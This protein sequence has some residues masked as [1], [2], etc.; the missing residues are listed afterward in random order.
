VL[1]GH[2]TWV[3]SVAW[4]GD[5]RRIASGS[6]D[7]TVRIWD[8][9]SGEM[10]RV[11]E[12]HR[13]WVRSVAW[14]GDGRRIAS[15]SADNTVRIWDSESGKVL[16][17]HKSGNQSYDF[18]DVAFV[19]IVEMAASLG[20]TVLGDPAIILGRLEP[21]AAGLYAAVISKRLRPVG[22]VSA[23]V[24]PSLAEETVQVVSAK[25]VLMGESGAGKSGLALRLAED[26]F[27]EQSSTHGMRRWRIA[28]ETLG[29]PEVSARG[30]KREVV[31]WD[32][33]GQDEYRL[34]HQL[35][36]HDTMI[37]LTVLD[38]TRDSAFEDADEWNLRLA[39]QSGRREPARLLVGSKADQIKNRIMIDKSRIESLIARWKMGPFRLTSA[40]DGSG[41]EELRESVGALINWDGL[42]RTSR[43]RL[44]QLIR[45]IIDERG[46]AGE[47]V[48]MYSDLERRI[49]EASPNE[50]DG[51]SVESVVQELARQGVITD[52][53]LSTG[54][55]ALVLGIDYVD[56]YAGSLILIARENSRVR[57]VPA[58]EMSEAIFR[59]SFP[60]IKEEVRLDPIQERHVMECVIGLMIEKGICLRHERLLVF[61]TLF[62]ETASD[63]G[64]SSSALAVPL[65]YD[66]SGAISN[67]YASLIARL[68]VGEMFGRVRLWKDRAEFD[69]PG[70]GVCGLRRIDRSGGWSHMD[71]LFGEETNQATR[72]LFT[73]FVEEH[74]THEGVAIREV[75]EMTCP[76]CSYRFDEI[77]VR[78][79]IAKGLSEI[80]CPWPECDTVSRISQG[81][82][83]MRKSNPSVAE[84]LIAL[85]KTS[86]E[87]QGREMN[88][89][90]VEAKPV[91]IF[92]SYSH[93]DDALRETLV[94]HLSPLRREGLLDAWHDRKIKPGADW[95]SEIDATWNRPVSSCCW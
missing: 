22:E 6:S 10:V 52:T 83:G 77:L 30:E 44:F 35:F 64:D 25:I 16:G 95:A 31:L 63:D 43:P 58:V 47:I 39:K 76:K 93:N 81:A 45:D 48:M 32:L 92:I 17:V 87:K 8:S 19:P 75:L 80:R 14:S 33:G 72:D 86:K 23:S 1:E 79:Y 90:K 60:G 54:N 24:A 29:A 4:S 59:S 50:F 49:K 36:L 21:D 73:A 46:M 27:E 91:K 34:I 18:V 2:R 88:E 13:T 53:H 62:P 9:E 71:L 41:I 20:Q 70:Q 3:R 51:G 94:R 67:I 38:P 78:E 82:A 11:L 74:L 57:G 42:A 37:A 5:G 65:Y 55:R 68:A 12:G 26:R 61:P 69:R 40:L 66:F 89:A 7:N 56:S 28:P 15:G 85:K 84:E